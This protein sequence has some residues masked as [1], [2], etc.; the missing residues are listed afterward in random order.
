MYGNIHLVNEWVFVVF[1]LHRACEIQQVILLHPQYPIFRISFDRDTSLK[2]CQ[3]I[4]SCTGEIF[5]AITQFSFRLRY[6]T[7]ISDFP[8][9]FS[10]MISPLD[11]LLKK[12]KRQFDSFFWTNIFHIYSSSTYKRSQEKRNNL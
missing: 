10:V 9:E 8:D 3:G 12:R 6:G 4:V 11:G 2:V 5:V 1:S 7:R